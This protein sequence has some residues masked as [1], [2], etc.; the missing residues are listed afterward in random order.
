MTLS[1][2]QKTQLFELRVR[3][4]LARMFHL[5][6]TTPTDDQLDMLLGK[7]EITMRDIGEIAH[8]LGFFVELAVMHPVPEAEA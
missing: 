7:E 3:G 8:G 5:T 1:I 6:D 2:T 4:M